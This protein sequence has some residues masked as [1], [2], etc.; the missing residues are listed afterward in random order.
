MRRSDPRHRPEFQKFF[1]PSTKS[2]GLSE[3]AEKM[4]VEQPVLPE[5]IDAPWCI[6]GQLARVSQGR[7]PDRCAEWI[8]EPAETSFAAPSALGRSSRRMKQ[9]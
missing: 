4:V 6:N 9:R 7:W 5:I 1:Y 2:A 8:D 3:W